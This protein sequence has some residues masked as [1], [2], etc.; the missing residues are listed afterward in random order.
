[1]SENHSQFLKGKVWT[2]ARDGQINRLKAILENVEK[3]VAYE[4]L[5]HKTN[6][7]GQSTTPLI[8][9]VIKGN[10]EVVLILA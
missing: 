8:I 6:E 9:A 2:A 10:E 4:I 3:E 7:D 5:S 1:M